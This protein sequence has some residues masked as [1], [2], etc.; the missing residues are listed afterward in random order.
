MPATEQ[1]GK[2]SPDTVYEQ[3]HQNIRATD[4]ISFKLMSLVPL[5]T[6][7]AISLLARSDISWGIKCFVSGFAATAAFGVFRWELRNIQLCSWLRDRAKKMDG[8]PYPDAPELRSIGRR[9]LRIGK[10]QAEKIIYFAVILAWLLLPGVD[11]LWRPERT[12]GRWAGVVVSLAVGVGLAIWMVLSL[13]TPRK[14]DDEARLAHAA[15]KDSNS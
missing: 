7:G 15:G 14:G 3:I 4:D 12:P 11:G 1:P 8:E 6:G 13:P 9:E 5:I 10:T 2:Q